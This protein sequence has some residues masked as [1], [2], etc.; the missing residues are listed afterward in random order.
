MDAR[1][2]CIVLALVILS[3]MPLV[4]GAAGS[5]APDLLGRISES[6]LREDPFATWFVPGYA[7]YEPSSSGVAALRDVGSDRLDVTVFFGSWCG[8]SRREVPRFVKLLD[9]IGFPRERVRLVG[10]DRSDDAVKRSPGGEERGQEIYRVPTFVVSRDGA[11]I[12]RVVEHP[13]LSLERDLLA[14]VRGQPYEP[15][16][17]SYPTVRRW[18]DQGLLRDPNVSAWGLAS[19]VRAGIVSE[20]EL[21][22]AARVLLSRGQTIEAAR[23]YEVNCALF[24]ESGVGFARLA[25]ALEAAGDLER[26]RAAAERA[27]RL[28]DDP[29]RVAALVD[30]LDRTRSVAGPA[31]PS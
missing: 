12:G 30:L 26:A 13:A 14:I 3:G 29:D 28:E 21:A 31:D 27:L 25:E 5:D 20:G 6:Q 1:H 18:L 11:E 24:P 22:A 15:S 23:L 19:Q 16:Y 2:C 17:A 4:V 9:A 7:S 8:D 10:V